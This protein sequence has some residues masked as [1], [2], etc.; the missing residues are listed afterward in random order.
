MTCSRNQRIVRGGRHLLI[1]GFVQATSN[2]QVAPLS[3][4]P[5][6]ARLSHNPQVAPLPHTIQVAPLSHTIQVAPPTPIPTVP[7]P[8]SPIVTPSLNFHRLHVMAVQ[9]LHRLGLLQST[10]EATPVSEQCWHQGCLC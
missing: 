7:P 5:Q 9:F 1:H 6:V 3:H 2:L 4:N 10:A 8:A